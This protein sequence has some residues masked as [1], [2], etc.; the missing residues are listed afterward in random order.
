MLVVGSGV[1]FWVIGDGWADGNSEF[2]GAV[3]VRKLLAGEPEPRENG[4]ACVLSV[5]M[6]GISK[7]SG[8]FVV[9]A[10]ADVASRFSIDE[11]EA[12]RPCTHGCL[13]QVIMGV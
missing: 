10:C 8:K 7:E 4:L 6:R 2:V 11:H 3:R 5:L 13:C 1:L 9:E 12:K